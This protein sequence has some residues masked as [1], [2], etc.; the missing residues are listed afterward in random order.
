MTVRCGTCSAEDH[1]DTTFY[2]PPHQADHNRPLSGWVTRPDALALSSCTAFSMQTPDLGPA[3]SCDRSP[4]P[5]SQ[6]PP[7]RGLGESV[8]QFYE[9][10]LAECCDCHV[11]PLRRL[12]VFNERAIVEPRAGDCVLSPCMTDCAGITLYDKQRSLRYRW[13]LPW[14]STTSKRSRPRLLR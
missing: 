3:R 8:S 2:E 9:V 5:W 7:V 4:G 10:L 12:P 1:R 14:P 13:G 11:R 6:A